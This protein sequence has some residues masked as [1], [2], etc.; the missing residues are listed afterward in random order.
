MRALER[1]PRGGND[2]VD[3]ELELFDVTPVDVHREGL[4]SNREDSVHVAAAIA[5]PLRVVG[6][7]DGEWPRD[8]CDPRRSPCLLPLQAADVAANALEDGVLVDALDD[9]FSLRTQSKCSR[10][11]RRN[12][13]TKP[14][15]QRPGSPRPLMG[16]NERRGM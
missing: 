16:M 13:R 14:R 15:F 11:T 12:V 10:S 9:A 1:V 3:E 6:R 4:V 8:P 7:H 5:A 2:R